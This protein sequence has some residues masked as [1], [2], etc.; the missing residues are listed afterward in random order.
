MRNKCV[1][2]AAMKLRE[3]RPTAADLIS[4]WT[5]WSRQCSSNVHLFE[6]G[7]RTPWPL[8]GLEIGDRSP[9]MP[10]VYI[11]AGVHGDEPAGALA[12]LEWTQQH[13]TELPGTWYL[14]PLVNPGGWDAGT[15][16]NPDGID[17]NRD[18]GK[19]QSIETTQ[20][21]RWLESLP[22]ISLF[23][24]LHEDYETEGFYLYSLNNPE[25]GRQI[26]DAV[27]SVMP[28]EQNQ[29]DGHELQQ[30]LV[31]T[32][33]LETI[34]QEMG[35]SLPEALWF[36]QRFRTINLTTETPSCRPL[37]ERIAAQK[38]A[39]DVLLKYVKKLYSTV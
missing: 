9:S 37:Q 30:G 22:P 36:Y 3:Q 32:S 28:I 14:A 26:I 24:S 20:H 21:Q 38:Q 27:S 29:A 15:R 31:Q 33:P 34:L 4:S 16:E 17:L 39:L 7:Q 35:D 19:P 11:S 2:L 6:W 5:S 13:A 8:I 25:L 23:I 12:L 1:S 18:Y 10:R